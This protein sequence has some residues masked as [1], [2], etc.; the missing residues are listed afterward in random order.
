MGKFILII[1]VIAMASLVLS[2]CTA[3][4]E[5]KTAICYAKSQPSE[6]VC[7]QQLAI[8]YKDLT[9][10]NRITP[11]FSAN[12]TVIP[13]TKVTCYSEVAFWRG[14]ENI[15]NQLSIEADRDECKYRY[16]LYMDAARVEN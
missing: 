5:V 11:Y 4:R 7:L 6:N 13:P 8:D 16:N 1:A 15:C 10:C 12:K 9:P 2:G 14:E 3:K